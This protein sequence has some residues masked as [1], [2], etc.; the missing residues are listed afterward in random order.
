MSFR[1]PLSRLWKS[2]LGTRFPEYLPRPVNRCDRRTLRAPQKL[3]KLAAA[4][5][6]S[7]FGIKSPSATTRFDDGANPGDFPIEEA[8][9][10]SPTS[11][12]SASQNGSRRVTVQL[13]SP[14][15][16]TVSIASSDE[17][18]G[19]S[20][21]ARSDK[22]SFSELSTGSRRRSERRLNMP[23]MYQMYESQYEDLR[24][25]VYGPDSPEFRPE[26]ASESLR[27][28]LSG[29]DTNDRVI[30]TTTLC[31]TNFQRQKIINA[32]EGMYERNLLEDIEEEAGGHFLELVMA[33]FQPAH[34]HSA[35]MIYQAISSRSFDNNIAVEIACTRSTSQMKVIRDAYLTMYRTT[36]EKDASIKVEG[37]YGRMLQMLLCR[38]RSER[39]SKVDDELVDKHAHMI[40]SVSQGLDEV[41]RNLGLF[42]QY[43]VGHSWKHIAAVIDKADTR[44]GSGKDVE[45]CI[46]KNKN[47]HSDVRQMLLTIVK[48]AH[49]PQLYFAEKLH[50]AIS[51]TRA[52]HATIIRICVS[53]SEIDLVDI[54]EEYRRK[55]KKS[56]EHDIEKMCSGDYLRLLSLLINP[57]QQ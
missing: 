7:S 11:C 42:E 39:D 47:M 48:V 10:T 8:F 54:C 19:G 33:L 12:S 13:M 17:N 18:G 41:S 49:N 35:K 30:I 3:D 46:R 28:A 51:G 21:A 29:I 43:F 4:V 22:T 25:T 16:G 36:L 15:S 44:R 34:E 53:R 32:Y 40:N 27:R 31:H 9:S 45:T 56:L 14:E 52:D 50:E 26:Q 55:Y 38:D 24:G 37:L 6:S 5:H 2:S 57:T 20:V 23:L 1:R